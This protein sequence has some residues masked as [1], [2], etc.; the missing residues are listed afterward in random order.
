MN[1]GQDGVPKRLLNAEEKIQKLEVRLD[2]VIVLDTHTVTAIN[3]EF[4][5]VHSG[6]AGVRAG[7][8]GDLD[9]TLQGRSVLSRLT[10]IDTGID[11]LAKRQDL[12]TRRQNR[13]EEHLKSVDANM[14]TLTKDVGE[15]KGDVGELKRDVG[16]LKGDVGS[17]AAGMVEVLRIL[18]SRGD[19]S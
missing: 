13:V 19:D 3:E 16:E 15:L 7:I 8:G 18:R 17:L 5:K 11:N 12:L 2:E 14:A 1:N 4:S 9:G 6:I 10:S